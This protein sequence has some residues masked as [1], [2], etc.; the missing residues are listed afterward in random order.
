MN[1]FIKLNHFHSSAAHVIG[2]CEKLYTLDAL[3]RR[4]IHAKDKFIQKWRQRKSF[5][6]ALEHMEKRVLEPTRLTAMEE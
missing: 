1:L 3:S 2:Y 4:S 6:D 5:Q